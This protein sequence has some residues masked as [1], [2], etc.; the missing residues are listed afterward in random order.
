MLR[1]SA[2]AEKEGIPSVSLIGKGFARQADLV[3]DGIGLP[4]QFAQYPGPPMVDSLETVA[5]KVEEHLMPSIIQALTQPP[6]KRAVPASPDPAP[7]DIVFTGTFDEIQEHFH[8]KL[9]TDG[10]PVVPPTR[11]RVAA[12]LSYTE[13]SPDEVLRVVPQEG[14]EVTIQS[15]AVNG[16]MAGCR[17]EYMPVLVAIIDAMCDP[18]FHIEHS[19]ST[20]GW[21]PVVVVSGPIARDLDIN[22][23]QGVMRVGRQSNT[24]I[25]RFV[26]L[27]LRNICGF[28]IPPGAGDK[29]SIAQSFLVSFAED[30]DCAKEIGWPTFGQDRGFGPDDNV[31]TVQSVVA[32]TPP[33][34]SAGDT[35]ETHVQQFADVMGATFT[36]WSHTGMKI[37][38]WNPLIMV[39]PAI[40][41]VIAKEMTKDDVRRELQKRIRVPASKATHYG[42]MTS[43]PTFNLKG[44]VDDG[45]LPKEFALSDDPDRLIPVIIKPEMVNIVIAGDP[46]RNQSKGY[47]ANHHHGPPTSRKVVLPKDWAQRIRRSTR[48]ILK[49]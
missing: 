48:S 42:R 41:R 32:I 23:G 8:R 49:T 9:W 37:G 40:A 13:R 1:V 25:G 10:M 47:M 18:D 30:E 6:P 22:H 39:G 46:D 45:I 4:L 33:T 38:F 17:P 7:D 35:A 14:R 16:V 44:L 15:I 43:T 34:Y 31:V 5:R 26:R 29:G 24:T 11:E 36:Y 3:A 19:G 21:E 20:P 12:F 2:L 28:R 27:F